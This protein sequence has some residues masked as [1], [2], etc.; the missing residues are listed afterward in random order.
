[1]KAVATASALQ[2]AR[3][4][5]DEGYDGKSAGPS[6]GEEYEDHA[7]Q[8]ELESRALYDILEK[9]ITPIFMRGP[10]GIPRRWVAKMKASMHKL[11][12]CSTLTAWCRNTGPF[13]LPAERG[14]SSWNTNGRT[15]RNSP[16]G[17]KR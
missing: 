14:P 3:R 8:D 15:S 11:C 13:Y 9:D 5:W 6:N 4:L 17:E 12:P 2:R 10:D 7:F 1:M 16:N